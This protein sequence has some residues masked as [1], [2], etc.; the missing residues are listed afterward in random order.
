MQIIPVSDTALEAAT[1]GWVSGCAAWEQGHLSGAELN[2]LGDKLARAVN[3]SL[4]RASQSAA[5]Q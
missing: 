2:D 3:S 1:H 4:A 5:A